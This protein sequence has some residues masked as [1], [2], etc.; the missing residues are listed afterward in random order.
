[1]LSR[2]LSA[3]ILVL[4]LLC[5]ATLFVTAPTFTNEQPPAA[6]EDER[7]IGERL[8]S[9]PSLVLSRLSMFP[10]FRKDPVPIA[11]MIENHEDAR[12][13]QKGL[14]DALIVEEILV[15][16]FISRFVALFD[17]NNL[18]KEVGPVRSL[19]PYFLD[20]ILPWTRTV[21]HAGGSP[22]A[23]NRVKNSGEFYAI[24]LLY[25]DDK[26]KGMRDETIAPPHNLFLNK[27]L[28][29]E[30]LQDTPESY[31]RSADWPPF[32]VGMADGG[33]DATHVRINFFNT[34]HNVS[35]EFLPLAE[36]YKRTNGETITEARPSNI[37]ILEV[38]IDY[39]GEYGRLFMTLEGS[40]RAMLFHS[41][42]LWQ[43]R[44]S[45]SAV[46]SVPRIVD[47]NGKDIPFL[48][49]Q[50]WVTVLPTLER[51]SWE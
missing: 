37:L 13:H 49:G 36:K 28:L 25:F 17:V 33:E 6:M 32:E 42:K 4:A 12:P 41:G 24:N 34:M 27:G 29:T 51:V 45:K 8:L 47:S 18:P 1:M 20:T 23:L 9:V 10:V 35:Y 40:G 2:T 38:P 30:L 11:V 48:N 50:T 19:R 44:F 21:F 15:E 3:V 43:G 31:L 22:E 5:G 26:A 14:V 16:G 7:G 39:I 46:G